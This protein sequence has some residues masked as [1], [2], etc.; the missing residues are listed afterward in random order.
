MT[1]RKPVLAQSNEPNQD[2]GVS[3][4][5]RRLEGEKPAENELNSIPD[6]QVKI[7]QRAPRRK[8]SIAYK[9]KILEEY[10]AC[11]NALARGAL[12][13]KEGLY[14]ARLSTWRKQRDE[15]KLSIKTKGK[16][17]KTTLVNQQLSRENAQL[18]KKLAQAE[19]IIELQKKVSDLLG[20]HILP[21]NSNEID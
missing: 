16:S 18:K 5:S 11:D 7:N 21:V 2:A 9:L 3:P 20:T 13:R 14:H 17:A 15:G 4:E 19:A 1:T 10:D 12:L 6:A 8:F